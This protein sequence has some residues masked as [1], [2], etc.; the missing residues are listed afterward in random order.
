MRPHVTFAPPAAARLAVAVA[1]AIIAAGCSSSPARYDAP[2]GPD[3]GDAG[4][5]EPGGD[6]AGAGAD[7]APDGSSSGVDPKVESWASAFDA[8]RASKKIPGCS[9]ALLEKGKVAFSRGFGTRG[10]GSSKP[11]DE[12]T[13]YRIGSNTKALTALA[14]LRLVDDGKVSLDGKLVD[15]VP[16]VTIPGPDL[17]SLSVRQLLTHET[18]LADYLEIDA[19]HDD[20]ALLSYFTGTQVTQT[21]Y[22]MDPPGTFYDYSNPNFMLAGLVAEQVGGV[23][24]RQMMHDRVFAPLGMT[25]TLFLASDAIADGDV[26]EGVTDGSYGVAA[27]RVAVDAYDNAWGRPAG[28]AFSSVLD[29]ARFLEFLYAGDTSVLSDAERKAMQAQEVDTLEDADIVGYGFGVENDG[30]FYLGNDYYETTLLTHGGLIPGYQSNWF[31]LPA[32]GWGIVAFCN[33]DADFPDTSFAESLRDLAPLPAPS[34]PPNDAPDPSTYAKIAGAYYDA[35]YLGH[36]SIAANG[37]GLTISMPD[38][39]AQSV[40]YD[41]TLTPFA[42]DNFTFK[43]DG[44][45]TA[46]TF[47]PDGAGGYAWMRTRGFVAKRGAGPMR[48]GGGGSGT[49][50]KLAHGIAL[51]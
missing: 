28:Y 32:S 33:S 1:G 51:K 3:D 48:A 50:T 20:A 45:D 12:R 25:R 22:F 27:G 26:S 44:Q 37:G 34:A 41:K 9:V 16:G 18:G 24:Y 43:F 14:V 21:E 31:M 4:S 49:R 30:G 29:Y 10:P 17:A 38:M 23:P 36:V 6:D 7:G 8:E 13:L 46:V 11:A 5:T 47:I 40:T 39:D 35:N 19:S 2:I 15:Y 42:I